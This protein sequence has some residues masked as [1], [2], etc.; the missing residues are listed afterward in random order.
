MSCFSAAQ[1]DKV[2]EIHM[3]AVQKISNLD[4]N[5]ANDARSENHS[6]NE[7]GLVLHTTSLTIDNDTH[8]SDADK[9]ATD[10]NI[11]NEIMD[12]LSNGLDDAEYRKHLDSMK[13]TKAVDTRSKEYFIVLNNPLE[14]NPK[15]TLEYIVKLLHERFTL[16]YFAISFE[17]SDS[18][19]LHANIMFIAKNVTRFSQVKKVFPQAHIEPIKY[20]NIAVRDYIGKFGVKN[21]DK[22]HTQ[23]EGTF[24]DWGIFKEK[25]QGK[26]NDTHRAYDMI[27]DG[28]SILDVIREQ[29]HM[30]L[31]DNKLEKLENRFLEEKAMG[32]FDEKG[33]RDVAVTFIYG[34]TAT[35]KTTYVLDKYGDSNV[36]SVSEY[37]HSGCFDGYKF[38]D[39][40][41]FDEYNSSIGL[42]K[43]NKYIDKFKVELPCRFGDRNAAYTKIYIISNIPLERQYPDVKVKFPD[44]WDSFIRRIHKV[45]VYTDFC[46]FT[47]YTKDEYMELV[48]K[49]YDFLGSKSKQVESQSDFIF[50]GDTDDEDWFIE[51]V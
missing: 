24:Y 14:R 2:K 5:G 6:R 25:E 7:V 29:K 20:S 21:A 38:Q 9:V 18:G 45:M 23:V 22:A 8:T 4:N 37:G 43:M 13:K 12:G 3:M 16:E 49:G 34:K 30:W 50:D 46:E 44:V 19:T 33:R 11:Y 41:L 35:G 27:E 28:S 40:I 32:R 48:A 26:R 1:I 15:H 51:E 36:C 42:T 31:Y 47:E 39:I 10:N 17:I